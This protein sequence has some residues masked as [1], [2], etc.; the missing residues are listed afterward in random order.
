MKVLIIGGT[1]TISTAITRQ[2]LDGRAAEII[3]FNRGNHRS[4]E[5]VTAWVGDRRDESLLEKLV[6]EA[7]AIDCVI[8]MVGF[9]AGEVQSAI[10]VFK[11]RVGQYVFCSTVDVYT[12]QADRYP[13]TEKANR[14]PLPSFPYAYR[15]AECERLL[16]EAYDKEGFPITIL[17]PAQTYGGISGAIASIGNGNYQMRRLRE[18]REIILHGD[19]TSIWPACHRDDVAR[20]FVR[21]IGNPAAIGKAYNVAGEEWMTFNQYWRTA[22]E[23]LGAAEPRMVHI[24][25]DVLANMLPNEASWC[26]ENFR[27]NNMFD[28][29]EAR[30]D[31]DF[32]CTISWRDGIREV[33]HELD[34]AGLIDCSEELP[35]YNAVLELWNRHTSAMTEEIRLKLKR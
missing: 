31:L 17:R 5:G 4:P 34:R 26:A 6:T 23:E 25:T 13:I 12:K 7:G 9:E 8:D 29:S 19:G 15:K 16:F 30:R 27:Y 11:G 1:G 33:I 3:H 32:R 10:R 18:G 20:A 35:Y 2:L 22:A 28:N 21:S 14:E 24:P